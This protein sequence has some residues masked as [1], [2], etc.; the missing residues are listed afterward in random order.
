MCQLK[1]E[2]LAQEI[3]E[4]KS[5][6]KALEAHIAQ[7][8]AK[9]SETNSLLDS[10]KETSRTSPTLEAKLRE[11]MEKLGK[12]DSLIKTFKTKEYNYRV[13]YQEMVDNRNKMIT[14]I[15]ALQRKNEE[16][17][18]E[19]LMKNSTLQCYE[20]NLRAIPELHAK[21]LEAS[22]YV[23]DQKS[24]IESLQAGIAQ[25]DTWLAEKDCF[26]QAYAKNLPSVAASEAYRRAMQNAR[27]VKNSVEAMEV[28][29]DDRYVEFEDLS[30]KS[31]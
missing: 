22:K 23:R 7:K 2:G 8:D 4:M 6:I 13:Q 18:K 3:Q 5:K 24:I 27:N 16:M 17:S 10:Y 28:D 29:K 21:I 12:Q 9:L 20:Q 15:K 19:L 14:E 26:L 11:A 31:I 25:R 1:Y 30:I